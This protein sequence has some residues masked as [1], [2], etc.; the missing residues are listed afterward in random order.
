VTAIDGVATAKRS[1]WPHLEL[2]AVSVRSWIWVAVAVAG[3]GI[4]IFL[5][6]RVPFSLGVPSSQDARLFVRQATALSRGH[7]LGSFDS[8]I[9]AKGP[10]YPA[11]MAMMYRW[12]VSLP[13]GD[14][15]M[16]LIAALS[17][18]ACVW[19]VT[20]RL[21][22]SVLV[23]LVVAFD[24]ATFSGYHD[25]VIRDGWYQSVSLLFVC[26]CF[27]A[28]R[29]AVTGAGALA[30]VVS[31]LL[32]GLS[33]AVFW[34]CR[35]EGAWVLPAVGILV[36]GLPA[37]RLIRSCSYLQR[38]ETTITRKAALRRS[39]YVALA[40]LTLALGFYLPVVAVMQ[41]NKSH[42]GVAL[43][44][45]MTN[46]QFA[47][48]YSDWTRVKAGTARRDVPLNRAQRA[49]VYEISP[50]ARQLRAS[51]ESP[52]NPWMRYRFSCGRRRSVACD[53]SG[54]FT[55]WAMRD[56]AV[57]S[58]NFVSEPRFQAFFGQVARDI[59][60][61]CN[62]GL[63]R[64]DAKLPTLLQ[65]I[66]Q[67]PTGALLDAMKASAANVFWSKGLYTLP[68]RAQ[69]LKPTVRAEAAAV[70]RG[71]PSQ[72]RALQQMNSFRAHLWPYR[73]L[74]R[75]YRVLLP[76][77][78]L[79]AIVAVIADLSIRRSRASVLTVLGIGLLVGAISRMFV[80][81][82][83]SV[84]QYASATGARYQLP[85]HAFVLGL[86]VIGAVVAGQLVGA[87]WPGH[88]EWA[89]TT[90]IGGLLTGR[91]RVDSGS[92]TV[93]ASDGVQD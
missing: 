58:G 10:S 16:W 61:A 9:L 14:E 7:W 54:A 87:R 27:L 81:A 1:R 48:A 74:I 39:G 36:L 73:I 50:A 57:A 41:A 71:F 47:R 11:F 4:C 23:Y 42:Y 55:V 8:L 64:C 19:A 44:N 80:F 78:V 60:S 34:L 29:A 83:V 65:P 49:A 45:D 2:P 17:V 18:G 84:T 22:V 92:G 75:I 26:L 69:I 68:L 56:A 70:I 46:G 40:V 28:V 62:D 85:T 93:D 13:L 24:P 63:L 72:T 21:A 3:S 33:G 66:Q 53:L 89:A 20:R 88:V 31:S 86:A 5:R 82:L 37:A 90:R 6:S 30:V 91:R 79:L 51:I 15:L 77:L 38:H 52:R 12:H 76:A 67:A 59:E 43:S 35:E 32:A 25:V